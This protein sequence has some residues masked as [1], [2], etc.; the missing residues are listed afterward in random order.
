MRQVP[1]S[2]PVPLRFAHCVWYNLSGDMLGERELGEKFTAVGVP[3]VN[4]H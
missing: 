1:L 3:G 2:S 4:E